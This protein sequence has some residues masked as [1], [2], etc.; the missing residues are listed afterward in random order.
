LWGRDQNPVSLDNDPIDLNPTVCPDL[1]FQRQNLSRKGLKMEVIR[2]RGSTSGAIVDDDKVWREITSQP[3]QGIEVGLYLLG[4]MI[5]MDDDQVKV[6]DG[7]DVTE[8][9]IIIGK[10]QAFLLWEE[11]GG[12]EKAWSAQDRVG[13]DRSRNA[14]HSVRG[15]LTE[16]PTTSQLDPADSSCLHGVVAR[17]KLWPMKLLVV[18][19]GLHP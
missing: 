6:E 16:N 5:P 4:D 19:E 17:P 15:K 8:N 2:R 12:A 13:V 3:Q 10:R 14:G 1:G 7:R 9:E 11:V 18:V